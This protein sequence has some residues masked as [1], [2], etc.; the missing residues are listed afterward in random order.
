MVPPELLVAMDQVYP[1]PLPPEAVRLWVAR[2]A[3]LRVAGAMATPA[4][5]AMVAVVV[6]LRESMSCTVSVTPPV[7]PAV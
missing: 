5:T 1:V 3:R 7:L 2:G 6:L 4:L